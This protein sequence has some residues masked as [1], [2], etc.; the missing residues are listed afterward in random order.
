[1]ALK[2]KKEPPPDSDEPTKSRQPFHPPKRNKPGKV[3]VV[4]RLRLP[5]VEEQRSASDDA[6]NKSSKRN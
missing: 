4:L 1:M 5:P 6:G 3:R 2:A